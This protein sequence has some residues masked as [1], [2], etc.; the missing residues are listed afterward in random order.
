MSPQR[1]RM[2]NRHDGG[3]DDGVHAA[4]RNIESAYGGVSAILTCTMPLAS[5]SSP[6]RTSRGSAGST[7]HS[8]WKALVGYQLLENLMKFCHTDFPGAVVAGK[9]SE[10]NLGKNEREI[11]EN[12]FRILAS[13]TPEKGSQGNQCV[14]CGVRHPRQATTAAA[15]FDARGSPIRNDHRFVT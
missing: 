1:G 14:T 11:I 7:K 3:R 5:S 2:R 15:R 9:Y 13:S 6:D 8:A 4:K 12:A 10:H